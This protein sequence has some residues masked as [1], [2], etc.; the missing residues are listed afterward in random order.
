MY[1]MG[2]FVFSEFK[3]RYLFISTPFDTKPLLSVEYVSNR[4]SVFL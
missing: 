4:A 3:S 1:S 2:K